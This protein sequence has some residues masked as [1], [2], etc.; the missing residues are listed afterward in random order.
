MS[1]RQFREVIR[2]NSLLAISRGILPWVMARQPPTHTHTNTVLLFVWD[3]QHGYKTYL[4]GSSPVVRSLRLKTYR[5]KLFL[6]CSE[7]WCSCCKWLVQTMCVGFLLVLLSR[8]FVIFLISFSE[9]IHMVIKAMTP[10]MK[11]STLPAWPEKE[12][13][14][15]KKLFYTLHI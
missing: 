5:T 1:G 14:R 12:E 15:W 7:G 3:S 2:M 9:T 6:V 4:K 13:E 11:Y 10:I 8:L